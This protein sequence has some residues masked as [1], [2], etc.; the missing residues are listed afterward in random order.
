M[1]SESRVDLDEIVGLL[2]EMRWLATLGGTEAER[3]AYSERK[4]DL[5]DRIS[6]ERGPGGGPR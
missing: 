1:E 5:L 3:E 6:A 4:Q 2:R